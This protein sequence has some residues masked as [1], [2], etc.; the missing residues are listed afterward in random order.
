[1][2]SC[3]DLQGDA[4]EAAFQREPDDVLGVAGGGLAST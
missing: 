4:V 2:T 3:P 1:M